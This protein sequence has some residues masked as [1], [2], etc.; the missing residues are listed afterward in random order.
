[1]ILSKRLKT[2]ADMVDTKIIYDIGCDHALLDIYLSE[3]ETY[4][5]AIDISPYCI[6][7]ASKNIGNNKYIKLLV[8][9]G[10]QGIDIVNN[11]TVILSGMGVKT[12]LDI[13]NGKNIDNLICQT[14]K[15]IYELRKKVCSLGYYIEN[16]K[17]IFDKRY[18]IIIKFKK[19]ISNY[20]EKELHLGPI[21]LK[22]KTDIYY[23]YLKY[24]KKININIRYHNIEKQNLLKIINEEL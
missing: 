21:L 6:E 9:N 5:I 14:N 12:I 1:M 16:E 13:I 10:L 20:N 7:K 8:N 15:N 23:D 18:Y 17:V 11:S 22:N 19:G 4:C 3:K 2:I 24:L